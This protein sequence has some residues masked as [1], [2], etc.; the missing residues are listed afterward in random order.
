[1]KHFKLFYQVGLVLP[2]WFNSL[3]HSSAF[4]V[5]YCCSAR[6]RKKN[7]VRPDALPTTIN[8]QPNADPSYAENYTSSNSFISP[9]QQGI[10]NNSTESSSNGPA[11]T[12]RSP[13]KVHTLTVAIVPP[14]EYKDV[15]I[16]VGAMRVEL[17][18]PGYYR[19]PPHINLLY[20]FVEYGE[21]FSSVPA[22]EEVAPS[23]STMSL[24]QTVEQ[25]HGVT[26]QCPPFPIS[27]N[28]F[29]TFGG[30]K[31][32]VLWLYPDSRG[33]DENLPVDDDMPT[34]TQNVPLL[35]LQNQLEEAFPNCRDL[36]QKGNDGL[37]H[38]HMTLSH[39][40]TLTDALEAQARLEAAGC[41]GLVNLNFI[42]DRI[43]LMERR[44][45]GGQFQPLAAIGLGPDSTLQLLEE[46][47]SRRA[48]PDMPLTEADWVYQER[49]ALKRRR[50]WSGNHRGGSS[51]R[52]GHRRMREAR[53]P[54]SPE[55][56]EAKRA[57]RK[58]KRE[59]LEVE[60]AAREQDPEA[61]E[62]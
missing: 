7:L 40:E 31:R 55:V 42:V 16:R 47:S 20:P 50:N 30:K 3:R 5:G 14:P 29:G 15:W 24:A 11:R 57:A 13:R 43:Y 46:D 35:Q 45:D 49:M 36:S 21:E 44:G 1:M 25:L 53:I 2:M 41:F 26:R 10:P 61:Q 32:G 37:F 39:F 33:G 60:V 6:T 23:S 28:A 27:L 34:D 56:I 54:D 38:P 48:F 8:M 17:L 22:T 12:P 58:A 52:G 51:R 59:D 4:L 9:L 62:F 18:D 19:W